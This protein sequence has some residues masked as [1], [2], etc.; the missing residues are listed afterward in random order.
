MSTWQC[1]RTAELPMYGCAT[2]VHLAVVHDRNTTMGP[3][4]AAHDLRLSTYQTVEH[5]DVT[6]QAAKYTEKNS[7]TGVEY[8][9]DGSKCASVP[10]GGSLLAHY[11]TRRKMK[12][13]WSLGGA[14]VSAWTR[15]ECHAGDNEARLGPLI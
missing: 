6:F 15:A 10:L 3:T 14:A 1:A 4:G 5:A 9:R 8:M 7:H 12:A 2:F 11:N 13:S